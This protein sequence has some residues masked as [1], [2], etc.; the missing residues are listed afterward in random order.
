MVV[1]NT[2]ADS[3]ARPLSARNVDYCRRVSFVI[4]AFVGSVLRGQSAAHVEQPVQLVA[5]LTSEPVAIADGEVLAFFQDPTGGVS[6]IGPTWLVIHTMP[7]A[8]VR[9]ARLGRLLFIARRS[10]ATSYNC[11]DVRVRLKDALP[12]A[13]AGEHSV[14]I[15]PPVWILSNFCF[16]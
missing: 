13:P 8:R 6:L 15:D 4:A 7:Q 9:F 12:L 10:F 11:R 3:A 1:G 2:M 16:N 14:L 5:T